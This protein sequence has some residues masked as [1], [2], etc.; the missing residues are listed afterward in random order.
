MKS[1]L[2]K[3]VLLVG[4]GG[5]LFYGLSM[6]P[7]MDMLHV[8]EL[9]DDTER[10][11]GDLAWTVV[12]ETKSE[13]RSTSVR[14][15]ID[16]MVI[17]ICDASGIDTADVHVHVVRDTDVNA[18]ALPGNHIVIN[19]ALILDATSAE[20][21]AGVLCHEIAHSKLGHIRERLVKNVGL[22][23]LVSATSSTG[24]TAVIKE[25]VMQLISTSFDRDSEREADYQAVRYLQRA[26]IPQ[27]PLADFMRRL[28]DEHAIGLDGVSLISTHPHP[29]ERARYLD[30]LSKDVDTAAAPVIAPATWEQ[31]RNAVKE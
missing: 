6:V 28:A 18:Y 31:L 2:I 7:W 8:E 3:L 4:V 22:T 20:E 26:D 1:I 24:T 23:A 30:E 21:V 11:L 19:S 15:A 29:R 25:L 9:S 5:G 12:R 16:S 13:V 17:R 27:R 10:Q 14:T